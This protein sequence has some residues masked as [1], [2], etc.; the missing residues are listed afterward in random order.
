MWDLKINKQNKTKRNK[1]KRKPELL[2][3]IIGCCCDKISTR[4]SGCI[5]T[6]EKLLF[7]II[8]RHPVSLCCHLRRELTCSQH[9][10]RCLTP[11]SSLSLHSGSMEESIRDISEACHK[12]QHT[13]KKYIYISKKMS[14]CITHLKLFYTTTHVTL[15]TNVDLL[16]L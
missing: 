7:P 5:L 10:A 2:I 12:M 3:Q 9:A 11:S 13:L 14:A 4:A 1:K 6:G 8:M 15:V 16:D